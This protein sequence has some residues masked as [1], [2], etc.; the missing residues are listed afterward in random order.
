MSFFHFFF[1]KTLQT[2]FKFFEGS[3]SHAINKYWVIYLFSF[4]IPHP[5]QQTGGDDDDE[6]KLILNT[7]FLDMWSTQIIWLNKLFVSLEK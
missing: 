1:N 5:L 7:N 3:V 2:H 4:Y 6:E